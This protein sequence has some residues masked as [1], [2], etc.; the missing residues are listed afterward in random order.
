MKR[1][2]EC[3]C[4]HRYEREFDNHN[5][6]LCLKRACCPICTAE[7]P[8]DSDPVWDDPNY[9]AAAQTEHRPVLD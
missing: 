7:L 2:I 3:G 8:P 4:G 9:T 6:W 5:D 1:L